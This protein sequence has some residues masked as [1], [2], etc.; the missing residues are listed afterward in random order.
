MLTIAGR[1]EG[2]ERSIAMIR[3]ERAAYLESGV[4][5]ITTPESRMSLS[6]L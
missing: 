6:F 4:E 1:H 5:G 3:P 2:P